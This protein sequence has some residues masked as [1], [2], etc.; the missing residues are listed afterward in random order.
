MHAGAYQRPGGRRE[1]G[2]IIVEVLWSALILLI[3]V[4]AVLTALNTSTAASGGSYNVALDKP[5]A[6]AAMHV[7]RSWRNEAGFSM[8]VTLAVTMIGA[9][10][11]VASFTLTRAAPPAGYRGSASLTAHHRGRACQDARAVGRVVWNTRVVGGVGRAVA[12]V[13]A[14]AWLGLMAV[15]P[16]TPAL[17]NSAAD[18]SLELDPPSAGGGEIPGHFVGFSIEWS[19]IER[20]MGTAARPAFANLLANLG[21]G[22]LRIGGSSQDLMQFDPATS[23]TNRV[24]TPEDLASIRE[25][26]ETVDARDGRRDSPDGAPGWGVILGTALAPP[27][28]QR[29]WVGPDHARA[30]TRGVQQAF[31]GAAQRYVVSIGLGNEPD[32]SYGYDLPRYLAD[33][34]AYQDAGVPQPFAIDAPSTSEPIAPWQSI[35]ARSV[36]TRFFWDWP[37]ILD[38]IAPAT[39]A[40]RASLGL[41]T[42]DHFYP[43]ARGCATD[44]YRCASIERILSD[45]RM[46]NFAFQVHTHA[47]EAARRSLAYRLGELNTAAGR[48]VDGVSNVAA[49]AVWALEAMF[50]AA[51]PQPPDA[52]GTNSDCATGA[53]GVNFHNAEVREFF[54]PEEGNAYYNAITYDPTP[55][56]GAPAAAPEYYALLLFSRF[57]QG[58]SGLRP[59]PV[60][61]AH[62]DTAAIKAWRSGG[63]GTPQRLFVINNGA[64]PATLDVAVRGSSYAL[65][66][67]APHDASGAG[68]TLDAPQV[69]I[70]DREVSA[71][72]NWP[73]FDATVGQIDGGRLRITI[74]AGEAVVVTPTGSPED[75]R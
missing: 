43:V 21:S 2:W 70:D 66:R 26:L 6:G 30:F 28:P 33:F 42:T 24:I 11:A 1:D 46:A 20:Y 52:P 25:T 47:R 45:E 67:M 5:P 8:V 10:F 9:L 12:L 62:P 3:V 16:A 57:A 50:N 71:D 7:S 29:P 40:I 60:R 37:A 4:S 56:A 18:A 31:S 58:T 68:R 13:W 41:A 34:K 27:E 53:I 54:A 51:C 73:G 39:K 36:R 69:R 15:A 17:T 44:E 22:V 38:A 23:N 19:L 74:G 32:L 65:H 55:A 49:S 72:G 63:A 75:D 64:L 61:A 14:L 59:T 48:G 35:V